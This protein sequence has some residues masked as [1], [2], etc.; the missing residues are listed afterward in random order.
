MEEAKKEKFKCGICKLERPNDP[1]HNLGGD[2]VYCMAD[3]AKDPTAIAMVENECRENGGYRGID[4]V[5]VSN[6]V[7]EEQGPEVESTLEEC[8]KCS[9]QL[10]VSVGTQRD[11]KAA[12]DL[13]GGNV[14]YLCFTCVPD[15]I[16]RDSIRL[17]DQ[18]REELKLAGY[19]VEEFMKYSGMTL[20]QIAK[21]MLKFGRA[22]D[23]Q[24]GHHG[25]RVE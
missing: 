15:S 4:S 3:F 10:W 19:D 12:A 2:C 8:D 24:G 13:D 7:R 23:K 18:Q 17:G 6:V 25:R 5:V 16:V 1:D 9:R 22:Q 11:A 20:D 14:V 21:E